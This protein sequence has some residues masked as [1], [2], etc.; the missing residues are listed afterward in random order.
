LAY[1]HRAGVIHL[2]LK[3]ANMFVTLEG[4]IRI[5]DFGMAARWPSN[6]DGFEREG[7]RDY[8]APEILQ[9]AYGFEADVF[10]LGMTL[11][12]CA[13]NIIVPAM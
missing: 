12:E 11:L 7:D 13:S 5:G 6:L 10:S 4:R 1:I 2:D 8:M 3:P 9:G